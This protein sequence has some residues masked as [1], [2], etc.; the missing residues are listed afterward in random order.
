MLLHFFQNSRCGKPT[1]SVRR[2]NEMRHNT[3]MVKVFHMY[4]KLKVKVISGLSLKK[5]LFQD[6]LQTSRGAH[7]FYLSLF[8]LLKKK[9]FD[10]WRPE[11]FSHTLS[12]KKEMRT[13]VAVLA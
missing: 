2:G 4:A 8:F 1:L 10:E 7:Q 11:T 12:V 9:F 3:T 13:C 6:R 5:R